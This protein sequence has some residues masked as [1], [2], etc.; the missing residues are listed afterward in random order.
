MKDARGL[1]HASSQRSFTPIGSAL[2]PQHFSVD[3][4]LRDNIWLSP[5]LAAGAI[6]ARVVRFF[7]ERVQMRTRRGRESFTPTMPP[8]IAGVPA[9]SA[10]RHP[11]PTD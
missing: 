8:F 3:K 11:H 9:R 10:T 5:S 2:A 7:E 4:R 6:A 1:L